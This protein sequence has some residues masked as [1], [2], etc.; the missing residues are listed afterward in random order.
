[1]KYLIPILLILLTACSVPEEKSVMKGEEVNIYVEG[2]EE[3]CER[4]PNSPLCT[5]EQQ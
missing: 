4:E 2:Y 3:F 1:M 5:K